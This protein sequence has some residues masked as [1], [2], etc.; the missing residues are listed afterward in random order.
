MRAALR[1]LAAN[2]RAG[3]TLALALPVRRS[4][5][6][7][8][9]AQLLIAAIV[10]ALIDNG[11][12]WLRYGPDAVL[13]WAALGAEFASL[14]VLVIVG[15]LLAWLFRDPPLLVALPLIVLFS[16][17]LV[18]I[19]NVAPALFALPRTAPS[20]I[21]EAAY[22][23]LLAWFVFVLVRSAHV[24]LAPGG[25]RTLRALSAGALLAAP[26]VVPLGVL[27]EAS[28]WNAPQ[29]PAPLDANNPA[30]EPILA[31]QRELQDNAL[32]ALE[33]HTSGETD[34]YF[35]AFAPDGMADVWPS[36]VKEAQRAMDTHWGTEGRSIVYVNSTASLIETPI[37]TITHLREALDEIAAAINSDEDI[38][39]IYV[40]GRSTADG[41]LVV[42]LPPLGLVPLTGAGL[43]HLLHSAGIRWRVIVVAACDPLPFVKALAD[44][45]S[46]VVAASGGCEGNG[47]PTKLGDVLFGDALRGVASF[48]GRARKGT[49]TAPRARPAAG[50]AR[51]RG[52][53]GTARE[54]ARRRRRPRLV[55]IAARRLTLSRAVTLAAWPRPSTSPI[56]SIR[57]AI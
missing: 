32:E 13:D 53:C 30:A 2:L 50:R 46:V 29:P 48:Q 14:G 11:A 8:D 21:A 31:L 6:R 33:D 19:V 35:V 3:A 49:A 25:L 15:A 43:A 18:Q 55:S 7:I 36:R 23:L 28:W 24:A 5:F 56:S 10:S 4:S 42:Q 45:E 37:A 44:E 12:D 16:L 17:P 41:T 26:L 1:G 57:T 34:L 52:D 54:A 51:R 9:A 20:W 27:P 38:V 40:A 22:W 47:Q 39:M